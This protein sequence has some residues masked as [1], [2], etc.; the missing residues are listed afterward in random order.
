M[1]GSV[2][3]I[4][5]TQDTKDRLAAVGFEPVGGTSRDFGSYLTE[6]IRKWAKVIKETGTAVE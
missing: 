3:A 1:N 2:N 4:L 6:E 5:S